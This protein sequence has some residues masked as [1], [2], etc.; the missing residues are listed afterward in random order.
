MRF[1]LDAN[2]LVS[3]LTRDA[4]TAQA[5]AILRHAAEGTITI[6]VPRVGLTEAPHVLLKLYRTGALSAD[7]ARGAYTAARSYPFFSESD[8]PLSAEE[9]ATALERTIVGSDV[10]YVRL[11]REL[12]C[13]LVTQD[14]ALRANA[15]PLA[16]GLDLETALARI[17]SN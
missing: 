15:A 4:F 9:F 13:P 7:S 2:I 8:A 17:A 16:E 5:T 14:G 3:V 10:Y 12:G 6:R 11:A 1:V